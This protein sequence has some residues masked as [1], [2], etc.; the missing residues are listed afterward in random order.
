[1]H[2]ERGVVVVH[3]CMVKYIVSMIRSSFTIIFHCAFMLV[4]W[5]MD[6]DLA[7]NITHDVRFIVW[8]RFWLTS[9]Y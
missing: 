7:S 1:M 5:A 8:A 2:L 4:S 3:L 6:S 9:N